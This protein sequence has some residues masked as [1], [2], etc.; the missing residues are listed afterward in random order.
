MTAR[1]D[2]EPL[3]VW[4]TRDPDSLWFRHWR[5]T[6]RW[7]QAHLSERRNGCFRAEF[8]LFDAP[9]VVLHC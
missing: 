2:V 7:A 1:I 3:G 4:D 5:E 8:H 6:V 9:C